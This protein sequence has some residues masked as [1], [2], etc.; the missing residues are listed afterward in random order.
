MRSPRMQVS[1][2]SSSASR[3]ACDTIPA[4]AT[5]VTPDSWW[6]AV[7]AVIVGS[8][9]LV[10]AVLPSNACT[11]SGIPAASVNSRAAVIVESFLSGWLAP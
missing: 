6:A 11:I 4:S 10:S 7:N 1:P 5:T 8:I 3:L 2:A 9:V